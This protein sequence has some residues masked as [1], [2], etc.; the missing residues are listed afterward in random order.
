MFP[1]DVN[2]PIQVRSIERID[3]ATGKSTIWRDLAIVRDP[4]AS[5]VARAVSRQPNLYTP[6]MT[7]NGLRFC[8]DWAGA[9]W[10]VYCSQRGAE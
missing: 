3:R 6:R 4:M 9:D 5:D 2:K 10:F 1:Y 8:C 7:D